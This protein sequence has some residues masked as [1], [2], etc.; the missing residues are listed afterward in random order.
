[1]L[2]NISSA[3]SQIPHYQYFEA[4]ISLLWGAVL[5]TEDYLEAS[6]ASTH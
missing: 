6:L 2:V 1:M 4:D 3:V 5:C